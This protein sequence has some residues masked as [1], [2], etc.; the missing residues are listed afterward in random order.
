MESLYNFINETAQLSK[1]SFNLITPFLTKINCKPNTILCKAG[2]EARYLYF[3]KSGIIR[4]SVTSKKGKVFTRELYCKNQICGPYSDIIQNGIS[5]Y[6][7]ETLTDCEIIRSEHKETRKIHHDIPEYMHFK[8]KM[9]EY[10][11]T[12]MERTIINLG[13]KDAKER[14]LHLLKRIENIESLIPQY[15]IASYLGITPIQLSRI[16]KNLKETNLQPA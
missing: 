15:Q 11:Y 4:A 1:E 8:I 14:Y 5:S 16:R 2:D 7:F 9:L 13:T 12:K 6:T 10:A 3:I